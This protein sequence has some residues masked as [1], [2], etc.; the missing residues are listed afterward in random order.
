MSKAE[1]LKAWQKLS[2][3]DHEA[4]LKAVPGFIDWARKQG[5]DYR[6]V[7]ACRYL[8]KRRFDG[9]QAQEAARATNAEKRVLVFEDTPQWEAWKATGKPLLARDLKDDDG[10]LLGRGW[11]FPTEYPPQEQAA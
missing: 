1:A 10:R 4:A 7:H 9:F 8:S 6:M 3:E 2:P 11:Y 5:P